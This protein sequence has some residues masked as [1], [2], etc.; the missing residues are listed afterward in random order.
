M[1]E[2]LKRDSARWRQEQD[3]RSRSGRSTG[4]I[5]LVEYPTDMAEET[6]GFLCRNERSRGPKLR[7]DSKIRGSQELQG[8]NG[9]GH[10]IWMITIVLHLPAVGMIWTLDSPLV[11]MVLFPF[12]L[13]ILLNKA[14]MYLLLPQHILGLRFNPEALMTT[15]IGLPVVVRHLPPRGGQVGYSQ[16]GYAASTRAAAPVPVSSYRDPRTGQLIQGYEPSYPEQPRARGR[17]WMNINVERRLEMPVTTSRP[18]PIHSFDVQSRMHRGLA[19]YPSGS[20]EVRN[21]MKRRR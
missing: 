5:Y 15:V 6:T 3:R 17:P 2:D 13:D 10:G 21:W 4:K 8:P 11:V 20:L 14:T 16:P 7:S 19:T 1:I 9:C 18:D 12:L